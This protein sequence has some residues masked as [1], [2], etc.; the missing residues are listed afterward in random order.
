MVVPDPRH[1]AQTKNEWLRVLMSRVPIFNCGR[2]RVIA[3]KILGQFG[4]RGG[5]IGHA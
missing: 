5:P 2:L 1:Y 3:K 4:A